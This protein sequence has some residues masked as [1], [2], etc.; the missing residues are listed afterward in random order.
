VVIASGRRRAEFA[1]AV[2]GSPEFATPDH[3]SIFQHSEALQVG[4]QCRRRLVD[5]HALTR[6]L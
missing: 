1:L 5:I 3:E 6:Q 4:D 2:D